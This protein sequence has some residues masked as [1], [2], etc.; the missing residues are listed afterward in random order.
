MFEI[1]YLDELAEILEMDKL[2]YRVEMVALISSNWSNWSNVGKN[3]LHP[4][5]EHF[6]PG[7]QGALIFKKNSP[8]FLGS[9]ETSSVELRRPLMLVSNLEMYQ[10]IQH[11]FS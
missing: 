8:I 7:H 9:F 2:L 11:K 10:I 1:I 3:F 6:P 5:D 4:I